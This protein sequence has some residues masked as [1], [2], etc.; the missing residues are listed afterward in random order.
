MDGNGRWA[1]RRGLPREEGH[2]RGLDSARTLVRV[3]AESGA[4]R[5]T[6]FAFSS[7]NWNRPPDEV[8]ALLKLFAEAAAGERANLRRNRVRIRFIGDREKFP[9]NLRR[10]MAALEKITGGGD[11]IEVVVAAG[12]GGRWDITQAARRA[13]AEGIPPRELDEEKMESLLTDGDPPDL[14]IRTGGE[15]RISN[16]LLWQCAYAE[17]YFT[18]T[19]WPDFNEEEILRALRDFA[20]RER[21]FGKTQPESAPTQ[22]ESIQPVPIPEKAEAA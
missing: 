1:L 8:R 3:A 5:V 18:D 19:L 15:R 7:E 22:P 21:R 6:L 4:R 14:L 11:R 16:F 10:A 9:P 2:R 17:L 20:K 12:Y 13:I